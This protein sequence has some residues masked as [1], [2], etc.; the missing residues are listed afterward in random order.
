MRS[1]LRAV[2]AEPVSVPVDVAFRFVRAVREH[3]DGV[4]R[5]ASPEPHLDQVLVKELAVNRQ[6]VLR[7]ARLSLSD[8]LDERRGA[9]GLRFAAHKRT[10]A[11]SGALVTGAHWVA[12]DHEFRVCQMPRA[13]L[14][15]VECLWVSCLQRW[16]GGSVRRIL[17]RLLDPVC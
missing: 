3:V 2:G 10:G 17:R 5:L 9:D 8:V 4:V 14:G 13:D 12:G 6:Q 7:P 15:N 11:R 16:C 1:V